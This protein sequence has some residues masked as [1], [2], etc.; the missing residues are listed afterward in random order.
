[1]KSKIPDYWPMQQ[2]YHQARAP[3]FRRIIADMRLAPD[4]LILDAGC[5]DAF[6]SQ[7]L[8]DVL[9]PHVHVVAVDRNLG[10][11]ASS[12]ACGTR[13]VSRCLCD[14]AQA[15]LRR[16][17]FD[18]VWLCRS[19]HSTPDP[20]R[21]ISSL[22]NL[23][24]PSGKLIVIENDLAHCPVLSWPGDFEHRLQVAL[25]QMLKHSTQDGAS[26]ERYFAARHLPMWLRQAGLGEISI[27]T[28]MVEDVVPLLAGIEQYWQLTM[29]FR[30]QLLRPFLSNSD[31]WT[32][33]RAFDPRDD[34]YVFSRTGFYFLEPITVACGLAP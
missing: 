10:L 5:G 4:A 26:I 21:H 30:G 25:Y 34:E 24:C 29:D 15:G 8:V 2:A 1:V 12:V 13:V 33:S 28:Y 6:Y 3:I 14:L 18:T 11:L 32:Y 19:L 17:C 9:G 20:Q 31:W 22:A 27:H 16:R 23:L 7:L